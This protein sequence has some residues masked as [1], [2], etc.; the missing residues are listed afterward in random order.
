VKINRLTIDGYGVWTGLRVDGLADGLSVLYGPNEAGKT[1]LLQ[2]IRGVLYGFTPGRSRYLPPLRGGRPGGSAELVGPHGR[3]TLDRHCDPADDGTLRDEFALTTADGAR[4]GEAL[5]KVVLGNV[6]EAVFQNVFAVGLREM[7]ELGTLSDSKAAELL[8]SL[9][10]GLDRVSLVEVVR[11][12]DRSRNLL[13]NRAGGSCRVR[14]LLDER[15]RLKGEIDQLAA[16]MRRYV[17]LAAERDQLDQEVRRLEDEQVSI[18]QHARE[19]ELATTLQERWRR[20]EELAEQ[21]SVLAPAVALPEGAVERLDAIV[22]RLVRHEQR[23]AEFSSRRRQLKAEVDSLGIHRE[24]WR[25]APRI[26]A[27]VEQQSWIESL[28]QTIGELG[29][30]VASLEGTLRREREALG[31]AADVSIDTPLHLSHHAI[32]RLRTPAATVRAARGSVEEARQQLA[33]AREEAD[34]LEQ[35]TRTAFSGR[36]ENELAGVIDQAG[37]RVSQLRRR[38]LV[39]DRLDELTRYQA[40]LEEQSREHLQRQLLPVWV[41]TAFGGCFALGVILVMAGLFVPASVTGSFG[42]AMT[43]LG[44]L[45]ASAAGFGKVLLER[46]NANQLE[47]CQR[48]IVMLQAQIKQAEEERDALDAQLPQGGGPIAVRLQAAEKE[49]AALE[50]LV[51]MRSRRDTA[52]HRVDVAA[53]RLAESE[54]DLTAARRRWS[55]SLAELGLPAKLSPKQ[56]RHV[57]AQCEQHGELFRQLQRRREE[58]QLRRRELESVA[59]RVRE[60]AAEAGIGAGGASPVA[61]LAQLEG[62][63]ARQRDRVER[64]RQLRH[65]ARQLRRRHR[66]HVEAASQ[67]KHQ[68]RALLLEAGVDEEQQLREL[69]VQAARAAMLR[70]E[71]DGLTREIEAAAAGTCTTETIGKEIEAGDLEA[72]LD[73]LLLKLDAAENRL[74]ELLEQRG[75]TNEQLRNLAADRQLARRQ[76][77]LA[78]VETRLQAAIRRWQ[79]FAVAGRVLDDIRI[80]YERDRQP[81]TLLEASGYLS[82][83]T[84]GRYRR[85]W[86]PLGEDSL[87]VDDAEGNPLMVESLSRGTREQ[88][89]LALRLALA[90]SYARRGAPLPLVLDDVLV[91]FDADRA[92]AAAELLRDFAEAGH[93]LLV[94]TCHEHIFELFRSLEVPAAQLPGNAEANPAV[95]YLTAPEKPKRRR[96]SKPKPVVVPEPV[97]EEPSEEPEDDVPVEVEEEPAN[98]EIAAIESEEAPAL[99]CIEEE[100]ADDFFSNGDLWEDDHEIANTRAADRVFDADFFSSEDEAADST[101]S[102]DWGRHDSG[103][104]F[105]WYEEETDEEEEE[106]AEEE[107]A[108]GE[109]AEEAYDEEDEYEEHDEDEEYDEDDSEWDEEADGED[110][111]DD[112]ARAA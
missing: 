13:V 79:V 50:E 108:F 102:A 57:V 40:D 89:F 88:L 77:D 22:S 103:D 39:D 62:A 41:V 18:E 60:M 45:G 92:R 90:A 112:P 52:R 23:V 48:Q 80:D 87:R 6:D 110:D 4:Q 84:C 75:Q 93:Q 31:F 91:N 47:A 59:A 74:R 106:E 58:L 21:I 5:L 17:R 101:A 100:P 12:L 25:Q 30:E 29:S 64:Y 107:D 28:E 37:A 36:N 98:D 38:L 9:T 27:M 15:T 20:R 46:S 85:V 49:L 16:G 19:V 2:F 76:L 95:L 32:K 7:Q 67:L 78:T 53:R 70:Q 56:V 94:F 69:A 111:L 14:Q 42:W 73:E 51:P 3:F 97:S 104:G 54:G 82:R 96:A 55:E 72:R 86:T 1:T 35:E 99:E 105:G 61:L 81:E 109:D 63:L 44:L 68:R 33:A 26:E 8:Y 65:E 10:A 24:L 66:K 34:S 71:R 11:E 43:V 83:L